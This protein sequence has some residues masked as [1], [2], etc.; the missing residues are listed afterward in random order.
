MQ[1]VRLGSDM[2][3]FKVIGLTQSG[4]KHTDCGLEPAIFVF[5]DS[6]E[7][8]T[9]LRFWEVAESDLLIRTPQL[10]SGQFKP[11]S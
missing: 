4:F 5:S 10:V 2:Y 3:Q 8:K 9:N 11:M 7:R 6:P 1:S